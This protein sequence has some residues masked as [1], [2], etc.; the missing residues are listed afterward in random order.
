MGP[1]ASTHPDPR[2][3]ELDPMTRPN[4]RRSAMPSPLV[5]RMAL[6][7]AV[8]GFAAGCGK[9]EGQMAVHPVRG[10]V[11]MDGRP[12]AGVDVV[13]H[14]AA[15]LADKD[16]DYPRAGVGDDGSFA[17]STYGKGDGAPAGT[18]RVSI[19]GGAGVGDESLQV[20]KSKGPDPFKKY[21]NP[22][23]SGLTVTVKDGSNNLEPFLLT[24]GA[25]K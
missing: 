22:E 16:A 21:K 5:A 1:T 2:P 12:A 19:L 23:E 18:Y 9:P 24:S 17:I 6:A 3:N 15:P 25:A 20:Q 7:W 14:P 8:A 10:K 4:V 11:M 13:L